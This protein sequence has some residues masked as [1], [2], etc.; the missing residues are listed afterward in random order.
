MRLWFQGYRCKSG[1]GISLPPPPLHYCIPLSLSTLYL[2]TH[3][4]SSP[5]LIYTSPSPSPFLMLYSSS[6]PSYIPLL[7]PLPSLSFTPPS[8]SIPLHPHSPFLILYSSSSPH[9]YIP[10]PPLP[11]LSYTP[12]SRSS[13]PLLPPSHFLILLF[14]LLPHSLFL[15]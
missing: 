2:L 4:Y 8:S 9:L 1:V 11:S 5:P 14:T 15:I 13:I 12:P 7:P 6:P 3:I 10:F